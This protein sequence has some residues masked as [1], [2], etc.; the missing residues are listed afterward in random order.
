MLKKVVILGPESTGKSTL[1]ARLAAHYHTTWVPEYARAYLTTH[2]AAYTYEALLEI[3]KGQVALEEKYLQAANAQRQ[4]TNLPDRQAGHKPQTCLFIDTDMHVMQ[5]WCEFVYGK[6]HQWI[7]DRIVDRSYD[8]FLLCD[9]DLPWAAD[10]LREY[11]GETPR[12]QL[13]R[14]YHDLMVNQSTPWA[15]ISGDYNERLQSAITAINGIL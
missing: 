1:C 6:C 15:V 2:G 9:T 3:A 10:I 12:K 14:M 8:L 13:F 5:V 7:I 11:P 4:T